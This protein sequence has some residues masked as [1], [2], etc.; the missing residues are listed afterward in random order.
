MNINNELINSLIED[1]KIFI[2][3]ELKIYDYSSDIKHLLTLIVPAFIIKYDLKN[4]N[5]VL[6]TFKEVPL[7]ET[8][9]EDKTHQAYYT[10]IPKYRN[11]EIITKKY[12]VLRHY[13]N[14]SLIEL[15]DNI[16]HE[17]NHAINSYENEIKV[18][19]NY[20]YLRTGLSYAKYDK[21]TLKY[22]GIDN[23]QILEEILNTKQTEEIISILKELTN[24]EINDYSAQTTLYSINNI[25]DTKY[26]STAYSLQAT[27]LK[28]LSNNKT[29]INTLSNLRFTGNIDEISYIFDNSVGI[30]G[31]YNKLINILNEA[32]KLEEEYSKTIFKK[33]KLSKIKSLYK[34]I[35]RLIDTFNNNYHYK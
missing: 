22:L 27:F 14:K 4:K 33:L 7:I 29:F 32:T 18:S 13:Q 31:S 1:T 26:S 34:E 6:T 30:E 9:E 12:I 21:T 20:I 16:I 11:N 15:I 10:S 35:N 3:N 17:Y 23:K 25:I 5:K 8:K 24:Y 2:D 28:N 19:K